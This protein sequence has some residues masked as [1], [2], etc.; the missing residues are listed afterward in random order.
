MRLGWN[1]TDFEHWPLHEYGPNT[2]AQVLQNLPVFKAAVRELDAHIT[3]RC[4]GC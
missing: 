4:C 3:P 1:A 2:T